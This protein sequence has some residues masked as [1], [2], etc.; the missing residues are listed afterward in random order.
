MRGPIAVTGAAGFVGSRLVRFLRGDGLPVRAVVRSTRD[1][2]TLRALGCEV[3]LGDVRDR[4][5]LA[6]AFAGCSAVVHLVA[7]IRERG[8][9]TLDA[10]N[11]LGAANA[12]AAAHS[13]G[14]TR[15][16]HM[17]TLGAAPDAPRYLRSRWAGEQ[18]VLRGGVPWVIFRPSFLL[19]PGGGAAAQFADVAR[20]GPWYPFVLLLGGRRLFGRLAALLPIIPVFGSG[21]Y[22]SMPVALDDVL[23]AVRQALDRDDVLGQIH[24]IGGPEVLTYDAL[25]QTVTRV[26]GLRRALVHVPDPVAR[27][28]LTVFSLLPNPPITRDEAAS[29]LLDNVCRGEPALRTFG[30][31][32]RP[33][34]QALREAL[35]GSEE[36]T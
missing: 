2:G 3:V 14:L 28:I 8:E 5:S 24:E 17:S 15:F 23:P 20:F 22:R 18:E 11:R 9:Q 35:S 29:L 10:V 26:L 33:V 12:V 25:M 34:E 19:G 16:V 31:T 32:L 36:K 21:Q 6:Q 7:I 27:A 30:L 4:A 13:G 1:A